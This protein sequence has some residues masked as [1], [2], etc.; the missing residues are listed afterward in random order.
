MLFGKTSLCKSLCLK[1]ISNSLLFKLFN[2]HTRK[3]NCVCNHSI[4][5]KE[6]SKKLWC[7]T[8]IVVNQPNMSTKFYRA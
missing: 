5:K 4:T 8:E 1:F 3:Y 2:N 7:D 6:M